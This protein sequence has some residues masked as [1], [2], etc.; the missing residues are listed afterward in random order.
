MGAYLA[1]V[2]QISA[3]RAAGCS[4]ADLGIWVGGGWTLFATPIIYLQH[5][6]SKFHYQLGSPWGGGLNT[7]TP[8]GSASGANWCLFTL[9]SQAD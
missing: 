6:F 2:A 7:L 3:G 1:A 8:P 4:G 5:L 9:G